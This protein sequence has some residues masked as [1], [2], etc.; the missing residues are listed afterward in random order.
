MLYLIK[1]FS[2]SQA[3][4]LITW[5]EN[6]DTILTSLQKKKKEKHTHV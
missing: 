3:A 2:I 4:K 5:C 6:I 1:S